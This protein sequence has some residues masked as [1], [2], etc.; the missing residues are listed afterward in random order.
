M[1]HKFSTHFRFTFLTGLR[2]FVSK[3]FQVLFHWVSHPSFHLSLTVLVHYRSPEVFSLGEWSPQLPIGVCRL[4]WY[5]GTSSWSL[6]F[7]Y[8]AFTFFG[9]LFQSLLLSSNQLYGSPTTTR[10]IALARNLIGFGLYPFRSSLT[11]GIYF[12]FFS[13]SY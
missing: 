1:I 11:K 8:A 12:D 13:S 9:N 5:S 2:L 4:P 6:H 3:R 7:A 10:E